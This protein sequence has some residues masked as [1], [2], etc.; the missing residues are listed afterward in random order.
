MASKLGMS[1]SNLHYILNQED[2]SSKNMNK[3]VEKIAEV[4]EINPVWL[5]TGEGN[6]KKESE[7][8]PSVCFVYYPDQLKMYFQ[9]KDVSILQ[10]SH[11]FPV[12]NFYKNKTFGLF[13]TD[14]TLSPKFEIGDRVLI[15]ENSEFNSGEIILVFFR[16]S[17]E[18]ILGYG[19]KGGKEIS[20]SERNLTSEDGDFVVGVYR[21]SH[22]VAST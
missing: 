21:E 1:P 10:S 6:L 8:S 16:K 19:L 3:N 18:L 11:Y 2:I 15:E 17:Q 7:E 13:I 12:L 14:L 20:I 4:L 5:K 9:T 22:R